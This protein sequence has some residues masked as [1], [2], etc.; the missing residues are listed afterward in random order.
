MKK[1]FLNISVFALILSLFIA[2]GSRIEDV[3]PKVDGLGGD[4]WV[5]QPIDTWLEQKI[6]RAHV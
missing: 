3:S 6:G 2:C 1:I 5:K 4:T